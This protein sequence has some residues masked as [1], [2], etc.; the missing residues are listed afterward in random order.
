MCCGANGGDGATADA[1]PLAA[2]GRRPGRAGVVGLAPLFPGGA[3]GAKP[4]L[5]RAFFF[6]YSV[7]RP[8]ITAPTYM[9]IPRGRSNEEGGAGGGCRRLGRPRGR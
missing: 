9:D 3:G 2:G 1:W 4:L 7:V 8:N 5:H 6:S